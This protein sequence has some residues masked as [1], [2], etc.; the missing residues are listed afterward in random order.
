MRG[1]SVQGVVFYGGATD[2]Y[3]YWV[4]CVSW[5]E[6]GYELERGHRAALMVLM[7]LTRSQFPGGGLEVSQ[8]S[9]KKLFGIYY[10]EC[11]YLFVF[12]PPLGILF[13]ILNL[14]LMYILYNSYNVFV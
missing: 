5:L 7:H 14:F 6:E 11:I 13:L 10:K 9:H 1:R 12:L 2:R 3:G 4:M 8:L